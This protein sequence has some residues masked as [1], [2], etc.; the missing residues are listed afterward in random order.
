[1]KSIA[2]DVATHYCFSE[3]AHRLYWFVV[4]FIMLIDFCMYLRYYVG[5]RGKFGHEFLEFEIRDDGRV[6]YANSSNY[7]SDLTI[8][9][10]VYVSGLVVDEI[11]RIIEE[12][13][14]ANVSDRDWPEADRESGEQELE[15]NGVVFKTAK[16][17]SMTEILQSNDPKGMETFYYLVQDIKCLLFSIINLHFRVKPV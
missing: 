10:E 8:R 7:K 11:R 17:G 9:K 5:H 6:R 4:S 1:M 3:S 16:I 14:L 2:A 15:V 12:A 13:D